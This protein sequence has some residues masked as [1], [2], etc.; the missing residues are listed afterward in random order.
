LT[1]RDYLEWFELRQFQLKRSSLRAFNASVR[2]T[3]WRL[4]R[5]RLLSE[6]AYRR[7]LDRRDEVRR[8]S[9]KWEAK[10]LYLACRAQLRRSVRV[11]DSLVA[12]EYRGHRNRYRDA[13]GRPIPLAQVRDD[14]RK[15]LADR[16]E[17]VLLFRTLRRLKDSTPVTV[18]EA[19][20]ATLGAGL[21]PDS[22]SIDVLI[23]KPG[24]TFPRV[25]F[26]TIDERWQSY[27]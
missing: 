8:E 9:G 13:G 11:S 18:D 19:A 15:D 12:N 20:V 17:N 14:L 16:E 1:V 22:R 2:Q 7:G 10:L 27:P 25:A 24:G 21:L 23:Y 3:V 5:D 4:V 6:E 26:P